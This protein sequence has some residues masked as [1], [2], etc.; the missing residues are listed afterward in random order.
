MMPEVFNTNGLTAA[1][2]YPLVAVETSEYQKT[3]SDIEMPTFE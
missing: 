3:P 2:N 1:N